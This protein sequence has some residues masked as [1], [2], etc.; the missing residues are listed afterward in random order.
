MDGHEPPVGPYIIMFDEEGGL[1]STAAPGGA[2]VGTWGG[3]NVGRWDRRM[4][5]GLSEARRHDSD[6]L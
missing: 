4:P 1:F 2:A 6:R 5:P 3:G